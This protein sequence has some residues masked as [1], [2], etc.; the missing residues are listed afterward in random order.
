MDSFEEFADEWR[1]FVYQDPEWAR[2]REHTRIVVERKT[3][4]VRASASYRELIPGFGYR[5]FPVYRFSAGAIVGLY[6]LFM[7]LCADIRFFSH[8]PGGEADTHTTSV[9]AARYHDYSFLRRTTTFP[10]AHRTPVDESRH[11]LALYLM[12]AGFHWILY[13]EESHYLGGHLAFQMQMHAREAIEEVA[14]DDSN[15]EERED[16][17]ALESHADERA[18]IQVFRI[19]GTDPGVHSHPIE[20]CRESKEGLRLSIVAIGCVLLLFHANEQ[21]VRGKHPASLTRLLD[22]F[23]LLFTLL[24]RRDPVICEHDTSWLT[25]DATRELF[26]D[27]TRDLT[28]AAQLLGLD[29]S[30]VEILAAVFDSAVDRS[31]YLRELEAVKKRLASIRER[32]DDCQRKLAGH[33]WPDATIDQ[34]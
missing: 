32:L 11:D 8:I 9:H 10:L 15:L 18:H 28:I 22:A 13:H 31:E 34:W 6:D 12:T 3:W 17:R 21:S 16:I 14:L 30:V 20:L 29:R 7:T 27:A 5:L 19:Y 24:E 1:Q 25:A 4:K 2:V 23:T 26:S 33:A